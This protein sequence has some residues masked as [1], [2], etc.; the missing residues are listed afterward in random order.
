[1]RSPA[2]TVWAASGPVLTLA[3]AA[4]FLYACDG[5]DAPPPALRI[6]FASSPESDAEV[7]VNGVPRGKTPVTLETCA[8]GDSVMVELRKEGFKNVWKDVVIPEQDHRF[9]F[10]IKPKVGYVTIESEPYPARVY[11]DDGALL[12]ETPLVH[13]PVR[14]GERTYEV[15]LENYRPVQHTVLIEEDYVYP[16]WLH[17][18]KPM[19]GQLEVNSVPPGARIWLNDE[20]Q[21]KSTPATFELRPDAYT[22]AVHV[23]GYNW[24]EKSVTVEPNTKRMVDIRMEEGDVPPG[25]ILIPAGEFIRGSDAS[26][27]EQPERKVYL[28]D[29]YID[30]HEVTNA[31]FKTAF[32]RHTYDENFGNY[33]VSGVSHRQ[34]AEYAK[35]AGKRLPTELEWEKA[36][37]G[38]NGREY[39]WGN[40]F[41]PAKCNSKDGGKTRLERVTRHRA[42]ASFYGCLDMAGNV[43]EWT[44]SWYERYPGNT[45]VKKDYG[46]I[47]RVLRGGSYRTG[48]FDVRCASRHYAK[49]DDALEDYGFRCAKDANSTAAKH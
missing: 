23:D 11:L 9:V 8:P 7:I 15:R 20:L 17:P 42:G 10:E 16:C 13:C 48:W 12:G 14:I 30:K 39:P 45:L 2:G 22:V 49:Q 47:Y 28:P 18:L 32:P 34:A 19:Q 4:L 31:E 27:D 36:A 29:F 35:A 41:D 6:T 44:S 26:P 37:R 38:P 46:Y 1:M 3:M 21:K 40:K 25:M 43:F 33:P 24:V 5:A